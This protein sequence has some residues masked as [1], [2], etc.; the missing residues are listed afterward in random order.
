MF[1][2]Y[3]GP[4]KGNCKHHLAFVQQKPNTVRECITAVLSFKIVRKGNPIFYIL[5][6]IK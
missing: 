3:L 1:W 2:Y 5:F 6:T 4:V